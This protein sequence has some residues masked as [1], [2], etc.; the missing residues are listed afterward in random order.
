MTRRST[1]WPAVIG[2]AVALTALNIAVASWIAGNI[3]AGAT[4]LPAFATW[5]LVGVAVAAGALTVRLW[6]CYAR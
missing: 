4:S 3:T 6:R 1:C 2:T 5:V